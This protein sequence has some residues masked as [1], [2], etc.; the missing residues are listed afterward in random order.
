M[1]KMSQ[2]T[3]KMSKMLQKNLPTNKKDQRK[4]QRKRRYNFSLTFIQRD[5]NVSYVA[6]E[7]ITTIG[8]TISISDKIGY[9]VRIFGF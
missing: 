6:C 3:K 4:N 9:P 7:T 8:S 2:K 5:H 1:K